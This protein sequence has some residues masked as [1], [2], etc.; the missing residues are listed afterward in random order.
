MDLAAWK[1]L[2]STN[3]VSDSGGGISECCR[4][5]ESA[6]VTSTF[7]FVDRTEGRFRWILFY[8][9]LL[10][11]ARALVV[12][13]GRGR[14]RKL[15]PLAGESGIPYRVVPADAPHPWAAGYRP[16]EVDDPGDP[17]GPPD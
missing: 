7:E 9:R 1:A 2:K 6:G 12:F 15:L 10:A 3:V 4:H 8:V 16:R 5:H 14:W 13:G 11:T 17:R